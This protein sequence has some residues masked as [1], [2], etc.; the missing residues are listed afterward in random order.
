[1]IS[2]V[3]VSTTT[4]TI[5]LSDGK[6]LSFQLEKFPRLFNAKWEDLQHYQISD[7]GIHWPLL[8]ED[9]SFAALLRGADCDLPLQSISGSLALIPPQSLASYLGHLFQ[10]EAPDALQ[11]TADALGHITQQFPRDALLEEWRDTPLLRVLAIFDSLQSIT[12]ST[13][14]LVTFG[15]LDDAL[16]LERSIIEGQLLLYQIFEGEEGFEANSREYS[17]DLYECLV[18]RESSKLHEAHDISKEHPLVKMVNFGASPDPV[19]PYFK[20]YQQKHPKRSRKDVLQRWSA[21]DI[22][23]RLDSF[24]M[25]AKARKAMRLRWSYV[26]HMAHVDPCS[27]E[28]RYWIGHE[29]LDRSRTT[30]DRAVGTLGFLV[31][32]ARQRTNIAL[33]HIHKGATTFDI[34]KSESELSLFKLIMSLAMR[35]AAMD[36]KIPKDISESELEDILMGL[37]EAWMNQEDS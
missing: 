15:R 16:I 37:G 18:A 23:S 35:G 24:S 30:F 9:I 7:F 14:A 8:D 5:R 22:L 21:G 1:M 25:N 26:S 11:L 6:Q 10:P 2:R 32:F 33:H 4:C 19:A 3:R 28:I 20:E 31:M 17:V 12:E 27:A 29:Q 13:Q 36:G 34:E